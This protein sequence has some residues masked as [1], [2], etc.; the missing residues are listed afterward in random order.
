MF[1]ETVRNHDKIISIKV[2]YELISQMKKGEFVWGI[3]PKYGFHIW[4]F[5]LSI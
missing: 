2:K 5:K 1:C 3:C 4:V